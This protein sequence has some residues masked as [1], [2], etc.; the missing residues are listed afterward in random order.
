MMLPRGGTA[1]TGQGECKGRGQCRSSKQRL[2]DGIS[3]ATR[4]VGLVDVYPFL[5]P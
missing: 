1:K 4:H 2:C 3:T 5:K